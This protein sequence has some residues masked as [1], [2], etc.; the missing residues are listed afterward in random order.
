MVAVLVPAGASSEGLDFEECLGVRHGS[1]VV[2]S[3]SSSWEVDGVD[4]WHDGMRGLP[5]VWYGGD[6]VDVA[7]GVGVADLVKDEV[8]CLLLRADAANLHH[9]LHY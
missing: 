4:V 9:R 2:D 7:Q 8:D 3:L 5:G 6:V 1:A